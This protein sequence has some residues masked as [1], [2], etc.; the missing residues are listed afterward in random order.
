M[1]RKRVVQTFAVLCS[2]LTSIVVFQNCAVQN[3]FESLDL[4]S[5]S[6]ESPTEGMGESHLSHG[7]GTHVAPEVEKPKISYSPMVLDRFSVVSLFSDVFGP[8]AMNISV[9]RQ[10]AGDSNVF[11]G[12]CNFLTKQT[13]TASSP[14]VECNNSFARLGV[15]PHVGI[16]SL[17]QGRINEACTQLVTNAKTLAYV[18]ARID[19]A[20][21]TTVP[22]ANDKNTLNL[23]TLFYRTKPAPRQALLDSLKLNVGYPAS[24][25]GW[26]RA[27]YATCVSGYWQVL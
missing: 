8:D 3:Q 20:S 11:G 7:G 2:S 23:F 5:T 17:R 26:Q 13:G 19:A 18:M 6:A 22:E 16:N 21:A 15:K 27:I 14:L 1:L 10:I 24:K 9:V 25:E 12:A 4:S